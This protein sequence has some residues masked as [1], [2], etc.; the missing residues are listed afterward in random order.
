MAGFPSFVGFWDT[1]CHIQ[2]TTQAIS[3][4]LGT[5]TWAMQQFFRIV[6]KTFRFIERRPRR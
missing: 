6:K 2:N 3:R 5:G 1:V 4:L